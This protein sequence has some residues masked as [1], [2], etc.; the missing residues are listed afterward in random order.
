MVTA[1]DMAQ[2]RPMSGPS[3]DNAPAPV[4]SRRPARPKL[5]GLVLALAVL[6]A[7]AALSAPQTSARTLAQARAVCPDGAVCLFKHVR[8]NGK[9]IAFRSGIAD[10]RRFGFND[11]ASSLVNDGGERACLYEH[12]DFWYPN[13]LGR[14]FTVDPWE[15][16]PSLHGGL[17]FGDIA[18][19]AY[20]FAWGQRFC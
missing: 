3:L 4:A 10:F 7:F 20:V 12:V 6:G 9:H 11:V 17:S 16:Q 1:R 15:Y 5:L 2:R 18:S 13:P 14:A 19:S 8:W